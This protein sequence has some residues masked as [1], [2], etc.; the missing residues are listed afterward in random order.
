M[1]ATATTATSIRRW[2]FVWQVS[3]VPLAFME[4]CKLLPDL[5]PHYPQMASTSRAAFSAS[6]IMLRLG[7]WPLV[8][9]QVILPLRE[10]S[11]SCFGAR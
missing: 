3:N 8:A 10:S 11:N 1:S 9:K 2:N 5:Q 4:A 7:Y 6:F